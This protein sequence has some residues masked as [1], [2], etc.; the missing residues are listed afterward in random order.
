MSTIKS[1]PGVALAAL[2]ALSGCFS[3]NPADI[4]AFARPWQADVAMQEYILQPPD[5]VTVVASNIA[6]LRGVSNQV[7]QSQVVRPDGMISFE[8]IGEV[9]VAGKTPRQVA[10]LIAEKL[11]TLYRLQGEYP[12]DIRVTNMSKYYYVIGMV[13]NPGLKIFSG[14]ESTLSAI[15]RAVPTNLAW[16]EMVQV[17]RPAQ[18]EGQ[19]PK[20]FKLDFKKMTQHGVAYNDVLLQEGDV[21]YVPPTILASIGLTLQEIVG[22]VLQGGR[23]VQIVGT[24][25]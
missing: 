4:E 20:V 2:L 15:S 11:S 19:V 13:Y 7:G 6:E 3:A 9:Q 16:E 17:I 22:P 24:T 5:E 12:I 25:E 14:R 23:A 1:L 21:V 18:Q 8:N 10:Q